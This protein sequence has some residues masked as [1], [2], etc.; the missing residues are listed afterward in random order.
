MCILYRLE[1]SY[2]SANEQFALDK[3]IVA[4]AKRSCD[5]SSWGFGWRDL[6]FSFDTIE[7]RQLC[8]DSLIGTNQGYR[9][10]LYEREKAA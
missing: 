5:K 8:I 4:L 2:Q 10:T 7:S 1:V 3:D 9:L 6:V